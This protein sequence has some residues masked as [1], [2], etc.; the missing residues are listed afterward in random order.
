ML[1]Y[2]PDGSFDKPEVMRI[3]TTSLPENL[4]S[5]GIGAFDFHSHDEDGMIAEP[6][7]L[8]VYDLET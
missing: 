7:V 3:A 2:R 5:P 6:D 8:A 1:V 4:R